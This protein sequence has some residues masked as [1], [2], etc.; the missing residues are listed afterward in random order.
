MEYF[1]SGLKSVLGAPQPGQVPSGAETVERLIERV[2]TSTL[3]DDRRDACR[4]LK[5]L[6][7]NY[8]VEVGAQGMDTLCQVLVHDRNDPE[9]VGYVMDALCNVMSPE[10]FE[11][12]EERGHDSVG[13]QF[14]EIFIKQPDNVSLVLGLLEEF[15]FHIRWPAVKLLSSMLTHR[16]RQVQELVLISPMGVSKLMDLLSDSREVVRNDALL[17]LIALTKGN[18]NIQK[19]VAFESAFDR[20]LEVINSEG[21]LDGGIVV[22][23]CLLLMLNLLKA[24]PSNQNFFKEGSYIQRLQPMLQPGSE[25]G[26]PAQ[27]AANCHCFLQVVR[28]MVAPANPAQ[29]T[30]SCQQVMRACGLLGSLCDSLMASGVPADVLTETVCA[31]AEVIRGCSENQNLL[32]DV[33]APSNP[34]R[35]AL[36][37]L[38]MSMV[39]EK[40]PL[41]LRCAVLYCYQSFLHRNQDGQAQLAQTL[42]PSSS[43]QVAGLTTGQLLC[44]GLF[45]PDVL[46]NWFSCIALSHGLVENPGTK[47]Q[48]LRVLLAASPG[49]PAVSLLHQCLVLLQQ[50][51]RP[52]TRLGLLQLL[53]QWLAHCTLAVGHL[54]ATSG[55]VAHLTAVVC[56]VAEEELVR[57]LSAF[58]L[59]L[60]V[61]FNDDS[62]ATFGRLALIQLISK[63]IGTE[64]LLDR[65][66]DVT[67]HEAYAKAAK[68]PQPTATASGDLQLDHEFCRLLKA[69]ESVVGKA[70]APRPEEVAEQ[71][72]SAQYKVLI[73]QQDEQLAHLTQ[74]LA[75]VTAERDH[76]AAQV[77]QLMALSAQLRD[78]NSVLKAAADEGGLQARVVD[79]EHQAS[80]AAT[81]QED[82]LELLADQEAK[83]SKYRNR[84]KELGEKV[85]QVNFSLLCQTF[86]FITNL[87]FQISV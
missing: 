24:N 77:N 13:G 46:T 63:R 87:N 45:S 84:L 44:G 57:G 17:L 73:R 14:T 74:Q 35:T 64:A 59:G 48:L 38:L 26:W 10:T 50:A 5:A 16:P 58:I 28:T 47:E 9:T 61:A 78:Q 86:H 62:V 19:I 76:L 8:R 85:D 72:G 20:L 21:G 69:L 31:V 42:L 54:L 71:V 52:Q 55:A 41:A 80:K 3:L 11:E 36:V 79:L 49:Q 6:S 75:Q 4:A 51:Q 70:V 7:K 43:E 60:C 68:H 65:V 22:E 81:D 66:A 53:A 40:Q 83:L 82:L 32:G 67:R 37:V 39:N 34:P 18:A 25:D 23:D 15:E 12:E 30:A 1:K 33:M 29:A 2:Q 56:D 27:R